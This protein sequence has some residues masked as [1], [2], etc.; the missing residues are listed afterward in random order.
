MMNRFCPLAREKYTHFA[1]AAA[2]S[3]CKKEKKFCQVQL[4]FSFFDCMKKRLPNNVWGE[5]FPARVLAMKWEILL[6][7]LYYYI[8]C[9]MA[10][11]YYVCVALICIVS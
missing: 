10:L 6:Q 3:F 5:I 8:G 2:P 11:Y 1:A 7:S 9:W 4:F